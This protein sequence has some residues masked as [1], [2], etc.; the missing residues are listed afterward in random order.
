M[1]NSIKSS[2]KK[3]LCIA[4][5]AFAVAYA[6]D[7]LFNAVHKPEVYYNPEN[8]LIQNIIKNIPLLNEHYWPTFWGHNKHMSTILNK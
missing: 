3:P 6:G 2:L 5:A 4:A 7:Y 1:F 8:Q